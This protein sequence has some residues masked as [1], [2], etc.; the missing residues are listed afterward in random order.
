MTVTHSGP[1]FR[2]RTTVLAIQKR[3][4][5][6]IFGLV[7]YLPVFFLFSGGDTTVFT[8]FQ[9]PF[10]EFINLSSGRAAA[11]KFLRYIRFVPVL[12]E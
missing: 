2:E 11:I 12:L 1:I 10:Q 3:E 8:A 7:G 6:H 9:F 4:T 5:G